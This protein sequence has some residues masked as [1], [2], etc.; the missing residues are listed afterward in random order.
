LN[1]LKAES[2]SDAAAMAALLLELAAPLGLLSQEPETFLKGG[3]GDVTDGLSGEK[4]EE[5]VNARLT[6]RK[7]K[8]WAEADRIRDELKAAGIE[9]EDAPGGGTLWRRT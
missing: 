9:L 8:N 6:A 2:S 7:D 1:R 4:I 5:L 3:A